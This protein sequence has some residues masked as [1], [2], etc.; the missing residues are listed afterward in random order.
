MF[1][2]YQMSLES[3][4]GCTFLACNV[5]MTVHTSGN[6][7]IVKSKRLPQKLYTISQHVTQQAVPLGGG[8]VAEQ[9]L[10]TNNEC[11]DEEYSCVMVTQLVCAFLLG[12]LIR[13][14]PCNYYP[15][16]FQHSSTTLS[17]ATVLQKLFFEPTTRANL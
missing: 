9:A 13:F 10:S 15:F 6:K 12:F 14:L 11:S 3:K 7:R 16:G 5:G 1:I 2:L 17:V 8:C 4:F